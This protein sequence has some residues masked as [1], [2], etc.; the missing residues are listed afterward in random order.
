MIV[1]FA[2]DGSAQ[3][4]H[5][6]QTGVRL[7]GASELEAYVIGV[8]RPLPIL[9][10]LEVT[11]SGVAVLPAQ[12]QLSRDVALARA[13][14]LLRIEGV[15]ATPIACE[16]DPAGEI[17]ASARQLKPDVIVLGSHGQGE[18]SRLVLGS[19][20]D[21]VTHHWDG[22]VLVVSRPDVKSTFLLG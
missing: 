14:T 20:C 12:E 19:V 10:A 13:Q 2:T 15:E 8:A 21:K 6:M 5:A 16:G 7:L 9:A 11:S 1:L 3:A 4:E 22:N 17:L 18:L